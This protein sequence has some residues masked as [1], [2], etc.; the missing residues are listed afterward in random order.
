MLS[1]EIKSYLNAKPAELLSEEFSLYERNLTTETATWLR[2]VEAK[3]K[4][5]KTGKVVLIAV[6]KSD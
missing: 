6:L 5:L 4:Q 2:K 1:N 3:A